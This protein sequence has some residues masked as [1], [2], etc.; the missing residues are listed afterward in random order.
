MYIYRRSE[1]IDSGVDFDDSEMLRYH[2]TDTQGT[3]L[4]EPKNCRCWSQVSFHLE[5]SFQ[6]TLGHFI[7]GRRLLQDT[8]EA[9]FDL[10]IN[11]ENPHV[12]SLIDSGS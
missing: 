7:E 9:I 8:K 6:I 10:G 5:Q 11:R 3:L 1:I 4:Y 12:F 2:L